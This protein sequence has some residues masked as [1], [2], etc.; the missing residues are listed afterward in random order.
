VL[1]F[2]VLFYSDNWMQREFTA[3]RPSI[4]TSSW[5]PSPRIEWYDAMEQSSLGKVYRFDQNPSSRAERLRKEARGTPLG[6]RRDELLRR[7][8]QAEDLS[9]VQEALASPDLQSIK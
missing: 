8:Q 5:S 3:P 6:V 7:A 2:G 1:L 4:W 9:R